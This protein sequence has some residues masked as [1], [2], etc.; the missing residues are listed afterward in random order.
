MDL[1]RSSST[2]F[3]DEAC[4]MARLSLGRQPRKKRTSIKVKNGARTTALEGKGKRKGGEKK[5]DNREKNVGSSE[6]VEIQ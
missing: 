5:E 2:I 1:A 3:L 4:S 6:K